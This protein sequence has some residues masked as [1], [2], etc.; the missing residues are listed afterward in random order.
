[1]RRFLFD[2]PKLRFPIARS[3]RNRARRRASQTKYQ[4]LYFIGGQI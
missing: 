2:Q 4:V 1:M 3:I